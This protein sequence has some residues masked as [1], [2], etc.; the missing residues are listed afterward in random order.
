M[1]KSRKHRSGSY[2]K[3]A[4]KQ[5]QNKAG[6][7]SAKTSFNESSSD[8]ASLDEESFVDASPADASSNEVTFDEVTFD[9]AAFD[10]SSSG[11]TSYFETSSDQ[12]SSDVLSARKKPAPE[13]SSGNS[14]AKSSLPRRQRSYDKSAAFSSFLDRHGKTLLK[15]AGIAVCLLTILYFNARMAGTF[16]GESLS[17]NQSESRGAAESSVTAE[18]N[19]VQNTSPDSEATV[20]TQ[21]SG[22]DDQGN[23]SETF[24]APAADETSLPDAA[25]EEQGDE[26][27]SESSDYSEEYE[28]NE[29][30][31]EYEEEYEEEDEEYEEYDDEEY[32]EEENITD[33]D[34]DE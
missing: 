21:E 32:E 34:E 19:T 4:R 27:N 5:N 14:P 1:K 33:L 22:A 20:Q 13:I 11:E 18:D 16:P 15:A 30:Y 7:P 25:A 3:R 24:N 17:A 8:K 12:T 9:E 31:E 26:E 29:E 2:A 28:E 23:D 10:E 6:L